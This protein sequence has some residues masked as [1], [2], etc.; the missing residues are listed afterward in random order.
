MTND[1]EED[2]SLIKKRQEKEEKRKH[3]RK[4]IRKRK[5]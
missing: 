3:V 4:K 5:L 1:K 2:F